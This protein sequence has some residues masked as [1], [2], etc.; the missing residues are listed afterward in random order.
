MT[1]THSNYLSFCVQL[2]LKSGSAM[3][4]AST[5]E[6][7]VELTDWTN[8]QA[9]ASYSSFSIASASEQYRLTVQNYTGT[10]GELQ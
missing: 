5:Y 10:A 4:T 3:M 2:G 8:T 7:R 9:T 6:A 1:L